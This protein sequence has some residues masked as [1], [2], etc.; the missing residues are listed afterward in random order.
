MSAPTT[1]A[2]LHTE[3][4]DSATSRRIALL[5]IVLAI[6]QVAAVVGGMLWPEP[7]GGGETYAYADI[8]DQ[9][10]LWW[11]L[12]TGL[13]IVGIL[14]TILQALASM[15]LVRHRGS[16][17]ATVGAALLIVGITAQGV[18]VAG[19]A[20]AYFFPTDPSLDPTAGHQAF[21]VVNDNIGYVF[22]VMIAGA[23]LAILGQIFQAV[24]LLRAKVVPV[25][26]PVGLLTAILTFLIPGNGVVGLITAL[27][28]AV[29]A[30]TLG[31]Y[32]Y[33]QAST[34][35]SRPWQSSSS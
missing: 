4:H 26:V 30:V 1:S 9:R 24:G 25:W 23:V 21:D 31:W 18:G 28:M 22:A 16:A 27:P 29:A 32:A 3:A 15:Y 19:W 8:A 34:G 12:L 17:W 13:A 5:A 6:T 35:R 2:A 10:E 14:G 7:S 33:R 11:G 20:T